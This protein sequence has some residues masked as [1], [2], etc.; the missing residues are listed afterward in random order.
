MPEGTVPIDEFNRLQEALE[1]SQRRNTEL[2]TGVA[3][4]ARGRLE[5]ES[6]SLS[7]QE[8]A[9]DSN[10]NG[11][12]AE[13]ETLESQE[14]DLMAEGKFREAGAIRT[15]INTANTRLMQ[16]EDA[17]GQIA[18]RREQLRTAQPETQVPSND[19]VEQF[20]SSRQN[21]DRP[22]SAAEKVWI[23][24][25]RRYATD[26]AFRER[27]N[28]AHSTAVG[29]GLKPGT[30]DYY[31][32]LEDAGYQRPDPQTVDLDTAAGGDGD[33]SPFSD[34]GHEP[35]GQVIKLEDGGELVIGTE[36]PRMDRQSQTQPRQ[37]QRPTAQPAAPQRPAEFGA[38]AEQPQREAAGR[39]SMA[40]A[41][42]RRSLSGQTRVQGERRYISPQDAE[43]AFSMAQTI[44]P[45][46]AAKGMAA[47]VAWWDEWKNSKRA[48]EIRERWAQNG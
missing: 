5:A 2:E 31:Q 12:R 35:S 40:A 20:I 23:R 10:I 17:K 16:N 18:Q 42:T 26:D 39:G 8:I 27:V 34:T 38:P 36:P 6:T 29:A 37:E 22:F 25:N 28:V 3:H 30:R 15:R 11:L 32:A 44:A 4:A 7:A 45:D 1:A 46:I 14:A 9:A 47:S 21:T 13:I 41:P 43:M 19:P 48:N 33:G 24:Q